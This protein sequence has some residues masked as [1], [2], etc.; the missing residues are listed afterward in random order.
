MMD[1]YKLTPLFE[2]QD[3]NGECI[4]LL[5]QEWPRSYASR[6]HSQKKSCR[7]SPPMSF[8]FIEN[9]SDRL[10][11]HARIC[12]IPNRPKACWIESVVVEKNSRGIGLG[13][14][15]M[16]LLEKAVKKFGFGEAYLCTEDQVIFYERCGYIRCAPILHHST[17]AAPF[18]SANSMFKEPTLEDRSGSDSVCLS[19]NNVRK[20]TLPEISP[21]LAPP[22]PA[23]CLR[24][25]GFEPGVSSGHQYMWKK[26]V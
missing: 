18:L 1:R 14:L 10:I 7:A 4:N 21:S 11:G 12:L 15:L 16:T 8:L 26:L 5:N 2:R 24:E 13:K 9:N 6:E 17:A 25:I 19:S 22:P 3:L 20:T 23:I